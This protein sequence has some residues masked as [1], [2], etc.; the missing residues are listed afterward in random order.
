M[1]SNHRKSK[2]DMWINS[3]LATFEERY[4]CSP[5]QK[6]KLVKYAMIIRLGMD[7]TYGTIGEVFG[8]LSRQRAEQLH[9]QAVG[10]LLAFIN[11]K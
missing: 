1:K 5:A 9:K 7:E 10:H 2:N 8:G 11:Q 6:S 4:R 3:L